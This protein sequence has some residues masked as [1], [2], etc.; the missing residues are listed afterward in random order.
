MSTLAFA[1]FLEPLN[2][3]HGPWAW[4]L[5][6]LALGIA[7]IFRA[8]REPEH[9]FWPRYIRGVAMLTLKITLGVLLLG[10]AFH[11]F[12]RV[13]LPLVTPMPAGN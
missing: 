12:A 3:L 5:L 8:I 7:V 2:A 6:P 9:R 11:L 13:W 1:P 10:V 4:M